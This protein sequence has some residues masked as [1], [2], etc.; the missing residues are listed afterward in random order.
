MPKSIKFT[1]NTYLD[2]AGIVHDKKL[3]SDILNGL[4]V[5]ST[6]ER[7][8]GKWK[9]GKPIY[10]K[11]IIGSLV[12]I[13]SDWTNVITIDNVD[14]VIDLNG[15]ITNTATDGRS[16]NI[17]TYES[18]SYNSTFSYCKANGNKIQAKVNGWNNPSFKFVFKLYF[19]YTKTTD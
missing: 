4:L 11:L 17:N 16:L 19:N 15:T 2:S 3:L 9:N 1:N 10:Q 12:G 8:I 18:P 5:Y 14:E 13:G 6:K 7:I